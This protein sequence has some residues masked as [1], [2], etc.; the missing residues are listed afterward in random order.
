[1]AEAHTMNTVAEAAAAA[2]AP[3][4]PPQSEL[5]LLL[6]KPSALSLAMDDKAMAGMQRIAEMMAASKLTIPDHLRGNVGDCLAI[7]MQAALWRMSPF[8]VAQATHIVGGRLGYE[9][10]LITAA[11]N[12]SGILL[13]RFS[14]EVFGEWGRILGR[15]KNEKNSNDKWVQAPTWDKA[16]EKGLGLRVTAWARGAS[17]P[18]TLELLLV[19][20][21]TR[22]STLWATDPIQQLTYLA[23][24]KW[25]RLNAPEVLLG[26]YS[27][28]EAAS[29]G[30]AQ[31]APGTPTTVAE[32]MNRPAGRGAVT[33]SDAVQATAAAVDPTEA[34][35]AG[36]DS[37]ARYGGTEALER[38]WKAL[39]KGA[40][41]SLGEDALLKLKAV[42]TE[43]DTKLKPAPT[44]RPAKGAKPDADGELPPG[45]SPSAKP[46]ATAAPA[47]APPGLVTGPTF[48]EFQ[49]AID[50]SS[51]AAAAAEH[52][53]M[54]RTQF[55]AESEALANLTEFYH[56]RWSSKGR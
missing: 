55:G 14:V 33:T 15:F 3:A 24:K 31:E 39:D 23:Q 26:V 25:A 2:V 36:L 30:P 7:V 29:I 32:L 10:K 1:M 50:V 5:D 19:Q 43:A 52:L 49:G 28:E 17:K 51:D 42:A 53:D 45:P 12:T 6:A 35:R 34:A 22:F 56:K 20:A 44:P 41:V 4:P 9:A 18:A 21:G 47:G 27:E 13:D 8:A 48:E 38:A 16:E 11:L 54:A 46:G 40:R 37:V